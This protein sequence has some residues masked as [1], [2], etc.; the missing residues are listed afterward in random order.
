MTDVGFYFVVAVLF[1]AP[2]LARTV[3]PPRS[4][5]GPLFA[6]SL[7]LLALHFLGYWHVWLPGGLAE[8]VTFVLVLAVIVRLA[9]DL[10][11]RDRASRP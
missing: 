11:P 8:P 4:L 3:R 2:P 6:L 9:L 7:G 10:F 5:A 1:W